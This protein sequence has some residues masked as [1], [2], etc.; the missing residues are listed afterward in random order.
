MLEHKFPYL[1]IKVNRKAFQ[2]WQII[3]TSKIFLKKYSKYLAD[4]EYMMYVFVGFVNIADVLFH[5]NFTI[6]LVYVVTSLW[7][8][9][10]LHASPIDNNMWA[11]LWGCPYS[12]YVEFTHPDQPRHS[13]VNPPYM[14]L[15]VHKQLS[16]EVPELASGAPLQRA[17]LTSF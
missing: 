10:R 16:I 11:R 1:A 7:Y 6:V 15:H 2:F 13:S 3:Q 17:S 8:K 5:I 9:L 12:T 14:L 4:S